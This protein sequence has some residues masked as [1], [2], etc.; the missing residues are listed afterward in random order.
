M[1]SLVVEIG[2]DDGEAFVN[3]FR[4]LSSGHKVVLKIMTEITAHI[5]GNAP[6]L[7]LVDEPETHLHPPLLAALLR[8]LRLCLAR[9]DGYAVVATHS[10]VVLQETPSRHVR[11][12]RRMDDSTT[13]ARPVIET[14][15]ESIG[16][17]TEDVFNLDDGATGWHEALRLLA[18]EHDLESIEVLLGG[19]LGFAARSYLASLGA[20]ES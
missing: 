1:T 16:L 10:P 17:I 18:D 12:I 11:V 2:D 6:S 14:F 5:D 13:A 8:S 3:L 4:T 20:I 19:R 9:F 15:G 7:V